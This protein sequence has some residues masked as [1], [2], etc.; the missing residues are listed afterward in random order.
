MKRSRGYAKMTRPVAE[1]SEPLIVYIGL[2][3]REIRWEDPFLAWNRSEFGNI[4]EIRL[5]SNTIWTPDIV[6]YDKFV[7]C[8][9]HSAAGRFQLDHSTKLGLTHL[10]SVN[11]E[12]SMIYNSFCDIN[13]ARFPFDEQEC[14]MKFSS[15]TYNSLLVDLQPSSTSYK[16]ENRSVNV[17]LTEYTESIEWELANAS[18]KK[19]VRFYKCCIEPFVDVTFYFSIRRKPMFYV[20]NFIVPCAIISSLTVLVFILPADS[21]EKMT[22]C[23]SILQIMTVYILFMID[24]IPPTS[25]VVSLIGQ[26]L[27]F[28]LL[29]VTCSIICTVLVLNVKVRSPGTHNFTPSVRKIFF[30]YLPKL[31]CMNKCC[32]KKIGTCSPVLLEAPQ[33]NNDDIELVQKM[34]QQFTKMQTMQKQEQIGL[35]LKAIYQITEFFKKQKEDEEVLYFRFIP[36]SGVKTFDDHTNLTVKGKLIYRG[37]R[38]T[39]NIVTS[40]SLGKCETISNYFKK[41]G[42]IQDFDESYAEEELSPYQIIEAHN[43][44][45]DQILI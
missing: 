24:L 35:F 22:L 9:I 39:R 36:E 26:Y 33:Q 27:L 5:P 4:T 16:R 25:V 8:L 38:L 40:H 20:I 30:V 7:V 41:V 44:E 42:I 17:D 15:W 28:T 13:V 23:V 14:K 12:P 1:N 21:C 3:L 43:N 45:L 29:L 37:I 32:K 34:S 19:N 2:V 11:W 31:L 10:G 18:V 6:L